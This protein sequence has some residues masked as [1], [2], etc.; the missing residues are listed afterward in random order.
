MKLKIQFITAMLLFGSIGIFVKNIDAPSANIV[1]WRTIIGSL[2]LLVFLLIK[3][4]KLDMVGIK[5]NIIPLLVSGVVLGGNWAFLF[6]AYNHTSVG[7]ATIVYYL[8]P[9]I[10][11]FLAPILFKTKLTKPQIFAI[12]SAVIGMILVNIKEISSGDF[13]VAILY[14]ATAAV[15]YATVIVSNQ[16]IKD[17]T[18]LQST[19]V[20]LTISAVVMTIYCTITTGNILY[21]PTGD[22]ALKEI[23]FLLILG[24]VHTGATFPMYFGAMQRLSPQNVAIFS[25]IDPASTLIFAFIFLNETLAVNQIL[26]AVLIFGGA[27]FAQI[28]IKSK[29][30]RT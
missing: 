7:T 16:F 4:E 18:G 23:I 3:K 10:V 26:G 11:F 9:I 15:F 24:I 1:Q 29:K 2:S 20:Q 25:Y 19:F 28:N 22:S 5:R 30:E 13:S 21:I 8:A 6:E 14:S 27:M 17:M 12:V